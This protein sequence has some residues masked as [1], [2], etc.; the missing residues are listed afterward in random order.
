MVDDIN[1]FLVS[2]HGAKDDRYVNGWHVRL[3]KWSVTGHLRAH[4]V[5]FDGMV[6]HS[7]VEELI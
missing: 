4:G 6:D 5:L 3:V 1:P 2:A 7:R